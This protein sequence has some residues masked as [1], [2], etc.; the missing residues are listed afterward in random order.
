[1]VVR[2][3]IKLTGQVKSIN[4]Y[5][6]L[7]NISASLTSGC[8]DS[9]ETVHVFQSTVKRKRVLHCIWNHAHCEQ[10]K[11]NTWQVNNVSVQA[12]S[13]IEA[14]GG[15]VRSLVL[16]RALVEPGKRVPIV[17]FSWEAQCPLTIPHDCGL[18]STISVVWLQLQQEIQCMQA[19]LSAMFHDEHKAIT[20]QP[21][22]VYL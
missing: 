21:V 3:A 22:T 12:R 15:E 6:K 20:D 9:A 10:K 14:G 4:H 2:I 8:L 19:F 13:P 5:L 7:I 18:P 17:V 11:F 16:S 1:M